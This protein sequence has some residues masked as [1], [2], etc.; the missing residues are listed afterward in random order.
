[1]KEHAGNI[2]YFQT[3]QYKIH[4]NHPGMSDPAVEGTDTVL[5]TVT[6]SSRVKKKT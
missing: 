1:M 6:V 5:Q 4:M 3:T 2:K